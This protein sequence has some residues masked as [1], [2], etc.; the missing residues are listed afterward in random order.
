MA[1]DNNPLADIYN[2]A[3]LPYMLGPNKYSAFN[4]A[5]LSLQGYVGNPTNAMGQAIQPQQQPGTTLN[6]SPV[7]QP[8]A[9]QP[10][11]NPFANVQ[12]VQGQNA[13]A[14]QPRGGLNI[15]DWRALSPDQRS[16][17]MG[18]MGQYAAGNAM[19]PSGNN[20]VSSGSNPSGSNPQASTAL[21]FMNAGLSGFNQMANQGQ[22]VAAQSAAASAPGIM[23]RD[24]SLALLS[25]PGPVTTPGANVP[26][27]A[28]AGQQPNVLDAF[29]AHNP[30]PSTP[31]AG[32]YSNAGF[33]NT[34]R[35]L[36]AGA[37]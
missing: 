33:F 1:D 20:F 5:P 14:T 4:G 34:L 35:G 21:G 31:G 32:G 8:A 24:Q 16:A 12:D 17:A 19:M 36:R 18:P 10:P 37:A 29:L 23:S 6:S 3:A 28:P 11:S 2:A 13:M 27:S 15:A 22:P 30:Q 9:G 26:Q 25:N 7:S